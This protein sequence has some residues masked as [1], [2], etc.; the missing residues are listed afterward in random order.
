MA[1]YRLRFLLQE[2]DLLPGDTL[3][4][5]SPDCHVTI[6]DP[7]VSRNHARVRIL[8]EEVLIED[9]GSRNGVRVNGQPIKGPT[10]LFPGDRVRIGTQELVFSKL[11][12]AQPSPLK[13]TGFLLHCARC[14]TPYPEEA[15]SC[16]T[17]GAVERVEEETISGPVA[18]VG[19]NWSLQL[20]LEVLQ[21]ALALG[22]DEDLDRLIRR[23]TANVDARLDKGEAVERKQLEAL[24]DVAVGIAERR[25]S[26]E[27]ADWVLRVHSRAEVAPSADILTRLGRLPAR[28]RR[29]LQGAASDL[30]REIAARSP[31][32]PEVT[33]LLALVDETPTGDL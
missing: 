6:E 8:G 20:L 16:P 11:D 27:W 7:L 28:E 12:I 19:Q 5:R 1:R 2:F 21:K 33:M 29:R 26:A 31:H 15:L 3:I 10:R 18:D 32:A 25:A 23:A 9:L 30:A 22:R 17:C 24:A 14:R 13:R 4:G